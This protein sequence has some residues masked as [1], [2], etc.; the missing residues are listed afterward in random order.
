MSTLNNDLVYCDVGQLTNGL[1]ENAKDIS[2]IW[3]RLPVRRCKFGPREL[4]DIRETVLGLQILLREI[5][6]HPALKVV[7]NG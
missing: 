6:K 7:S 1:R 3:F 5:D 2:D 4:L